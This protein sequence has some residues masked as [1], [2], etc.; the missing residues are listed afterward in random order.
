MEHFN[1]KVILLQLLV[2]LLAS[3]AFVA[4]GY[5]Y[6]L[7]LAGLYLE[8]EDTAAFTES[9]L[10]FGVDT[11]RLR[12][13]NLVLWAAPFAGALFGVALSFIANRRKKYSHLNTLAVAG[14]A[15]LLGL[16]GLLNHLLLKGLL[17]APG[18]LVSD[19][20]A[21]AYTLNYLLLL[22]LSFWL[23]FSKRVLP[24]ANPKHKV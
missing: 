17:F 5:I 8:T 14:M 11:K 1:W 21:T 24:A 15:L 3:Y 13:F 7:P 4:L 20:A 6:D 19:S 10:Q 18:R 2:L 12:N 23:A 16:T 9:A 22:G